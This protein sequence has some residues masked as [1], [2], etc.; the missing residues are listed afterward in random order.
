M[1]GRRDARLMASCDAMHHTAWSAEAALARMEQ[2]AEVLALP[3]PR[4]V[5]E[6]QPLPSPPP[7]CPCH[8]T[9]AYGMGCQGCMA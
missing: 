6:Q 3:L 4:A 2:L 8:S 7:A 1:H 5:G 9:A